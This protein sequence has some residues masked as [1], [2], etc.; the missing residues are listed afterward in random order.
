MTQPDE[1]EG[2]YLQD[3]QLFDQCSM[4]AQLNRTRQCITLFIRSLQQDPQGNCRFVSSTL[5]LINLTKT[6]G[7]DGRY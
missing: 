7:N 3:T 6:E 1:D 5:R 2:Y 4:I